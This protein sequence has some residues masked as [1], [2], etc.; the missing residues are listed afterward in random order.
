MANPNSTVA[1]AAY[2]RKNQEEPVSLRSYILQGS[3]WMGVMLAL[4]YT[5]G[6]RF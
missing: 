3:V 4:F 2:V 1:P 5:A 6:L